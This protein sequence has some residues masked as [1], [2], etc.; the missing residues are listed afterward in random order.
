M[1]NCWKKRKDERFAA[2]QAHAAEQA[3]LFAL[4]R[5]NQATP[6]PSPSPS[7]NTPKTHGKPPSSNAETS[8]GGSKQHGGGETAIDIQEDPSYENVISGQQIPVGRKKQSIDV[9]GSGE[10]NIADGTSWEADEEGSSM[11]HNGMDGESNPQ[12]TPRASNPS[13]DVAVYHTP[14][15]DNPMRTN[16]VHKP[17]TKKPTRKY[18]LP[19][20]IENTHMTKILEDSIGKEDTEKAL[21]RWKFSR[22]K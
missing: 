14:P 1:R 12:T 13:R 8:L 9:L 15:Q 18:G 4:S 7:P 10:R 22:P 19:P 16:K 17:K 5:S 2:L 11:N 20:R 3:A 6:F 21:R